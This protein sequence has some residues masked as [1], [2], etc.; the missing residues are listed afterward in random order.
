MAVFGAAGVRERQMSGGANIRALARPVSSRDRL[1]IFRIASLAVIAARR[2][3]FAVVVCPSLRLSVRPSVTNR[4]CI[5]TAGQVELGLGIEASFRLSHTIRKFGKRPKLGYFR[6]ELY[7]NFRLI[8]NF[9]TT[10]RSK[11]QQNS[12]SSSSTV[13]L[14]DDTYTTV[15]ESWLF[16]QVGQL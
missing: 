11:C 10:S 2:C 14:V 9:A 3:V 5:V 12:S 16:I 6:L 13:K 7:P 15:D 4:Y 1:A 8:K